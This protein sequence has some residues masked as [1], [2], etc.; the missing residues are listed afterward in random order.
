VKLVDNFRNSREDQAAL[1]AY[2]KKA[3]TGI[4]EE[5]HSF[6]GSMVRQKLDKF[7]NDM[8]VELIEDKA[9]DDLQIIRING[10]VVGG[11]V[12]L[13]IFLLTFWI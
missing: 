5:N 10:S 1:D 9:G 13:A 11:L 4:I 7:S 8:L 12:G 2:V 3:L 6:I